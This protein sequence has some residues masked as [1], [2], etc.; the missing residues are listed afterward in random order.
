[1]K[2]EKFFGLFALV[3]LLVIGLAACGDSNSVT[4]KV[5]PQLSNL[6]EYM[7][8][9][10]QEVVVSLAEETK[11]DKVY[12]TILSSLAL[13]VKQAVAS[14]YGFDLE[15]IV[16]DKNHV[17]IASLPNY[18]IDDSYD[19]DSEDLHNYLTSGSVRAQMKYFR[20]KSEWKEEDQKKWDKIRKEGVYIL[21]KPSWSSAK[22]ASYKGGT[23]MTVNE[24]FDNSVDFSDDSDDDS[25]S[26][27]NA[28]SEDWDTLL[29]SY[30]SYVT[31]YISCVRKAASG[32]MEAL[33]EY[34]D[35]L[36]KAQELSEKMMNAQDNMSV[37]QWARYMEITNKMTQAAT[38]MR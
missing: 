15:V 25:F 23:N 1:M 4:L 38:D 36:Q 3:S 11:D 10:D 2:K 33:S 8:V 24:T 28:G 16:L 20:E 22:Y 35:L 12:K 14:D 29:D 30:E 34:A 6:G 5:E 17:E 27:S 32:D 19:Y 13:T 21:V 31:Q 37:S 18:D 26:S 7:D 9:D